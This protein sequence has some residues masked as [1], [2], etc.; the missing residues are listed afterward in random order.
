LNIDGSIIAKSGLP[1]NLRVSGP[2]V[3]GCYYA[4]GTISEDQDV[5]GLAS[6]GQG[7]AFLAKLQP[8][9]TLGW[10]LQ[11]AEGPFANYRFPAIGLNGEVYFAGGFTGPL[12]IGTRTYDMPYQAFAYIAKIDSNAPGDQPRFRT[13]PISQDIKEG[14][15]LALG[16][17]ASG[18]GPLAFQWFRNGAAIPGLTNRM[19]VITNAAKSDQGNYA[20]RAVNRWGAAHSETAAVLIQPGPLFSRWPEHLT[21]SPGQTA[22]F[23]AASPKLGRWQWIK[24]G[25]PMAGQTNSML[26]LSNI[27]ILDVGPYAVQFSSVGQTEVS[28]DAALDLW[29]PSPEPVADWTVFSFPGRL[30]DVQYVPSD[31]VFYGLR[32]D[33]S[34]L[35]LFSIWTNGTSSVSNL[36]LPRQQL[37]LYGPKEIYFWDF[38]GRKEESVLGQPARVAHSIKF[39]S[40]LQLQVSEQTV[41]F[42]FGGDGPYK[43]GAGLYLFHDDG[44]MR[45]AGPD[46]LRVMTKN[47]PPLTGIRNA[48][49]S[50]GGDILF[51]TSYLNRDY[52]SSS[53]LEFLGSPL[54]AETV[55][56]ASR[57]TEYGDRVWVGQLWDYGS[58]ANLSSVQHGPNGSTYIGGAFEADTFWNNSLFLNGLTNGV[59]AFLAKVDALGNISWTAEGRGLAGFRHMS[60][61]EV[62]SVSVDRHGNAFLAGSLAPNR[63]VAWGRI[64]VDPL[65]TLLEHSYLIKLD[66]AGVARWGLALDIFEAN[67]L[68]VNFEGDLVV[69][70]VS[71]GR[72][73]AFRIPAPG[74]P[75]VIGEPRILVA[76][77]NT[78]YALAPSVETDGATGYQWLRDGQ[79]IP[80]ANT[81]NLAAAIDQLASLYSLVAWNAYGRTTNHFAFLGVEAA[82]ILNVSAAG[83]A[84]QLS[85]NMNA[86]SYRL[87]STSDLR[88]PFAAINPNR[89]LDFPAKQIR[90]SIPANPAPAAYY[91]LAK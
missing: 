2:D 49:V 35:A 69:A 14:T 36:V 12:R 1:G 64:R 56:L 26:V 83:N 89:T 47:G 38:L 72:L 40:S 30:L 51:L 74:P 5:F 45:F 85:W 28:P 67:P 9:G 32:G 91:R 76:P 61:S 70:P 24:D 10:I 48:P 25:E 54:R 43:V 60:G 66:R 79:P 58:I 65:N 88:Q 46:G 11:I 59:G 21:L 75:R 55:A 19:L 4:A 80:S 39:A 17:F 62:H 50:L 16:A 81:A 63:P 42:S 86:S 57:V 34:S 29:Q 33:N 44:K 77:P 3:D 68:A 13:Q 90:A 18:E 71:G 6:F 82:P 41:P 87:Q 27:S 15:R 22:T 31:H 53:I 73:Q 7:D 20:V 84:I 8:D 37:S 78:T 23:S 52:L